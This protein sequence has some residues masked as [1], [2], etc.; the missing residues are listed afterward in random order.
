ME[1]TEEQKERE[2][3]R[4]SKDIERIKAAK[5]RDDEEEIQATKRKE[6]L[7]KEEQEWEK[8]KK[9]REVDKVM[10]AAQ[11]QV[12]EQ[13][14]REK[15]A[16]DISGGKNKKK[17]KDGTKAMLKLLQGSVG[18][19]GKKKK[20]DKGEF[21][22]RMDRIE[23]YLESLYEEDIEKKIKGTA[24]LLQLVQDPANLEYF[25]ES[26]TVLGA[27]SRVLAEDRKKSTELVTN[28]LE[29]FFC[30]S[31]FS[32]LHQILLQ[33]KIGDTT[34][35]IVDLEIKR[36]EL[37]AQER[38]AAA[39]KKNAKYFQKQE[40]LLFVCFYILLNLAEDTAIELKMKSR[41]IIR[42][43]VS[44]LKRTNAD[45]KF[46]D[47]LHLLIVTFLKKLSIFAEN[48]S[49]MVESELVRRLAPFLR[50]ENEDLLEAVMRLVYNL[51]F[52]GDHKLSMVNCNMVPFFIDCLKVP[53]CR[54]VSV[55]ILY[56]LS[57]DQD[58]RNKAIIEAALSQ[59][60]PLIALFV[61]QCALHT[62]THT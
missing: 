47:E 29:I 56:N 9:Q 2:K 35:R 3:K 23:D 20:K 36:Y 60:V 11:Q 19:G 14:E 61:I 7:E 39:A 32:Q 59:C 53:A 54:Q 18:G 33:N 45:R 10:A 17:K 28:I 52:D 44:M 55:R 12:Q 42:H 46:L 15:R 49:E 27:L 4:K 43:L 25:I 58:P 26:D 34:M 50:M 41:N 48:K 37:K 51:S 13:L 21:G 38:G 1:M 30:F 6:E 31:S 24:M 40:R 5:E 16:G 62:H 22:A 8:E 57:C